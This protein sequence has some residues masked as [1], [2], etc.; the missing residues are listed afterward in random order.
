MDC[1]P[2]G[3]ER[4]S[5][6][7]RNLAGFGKGGEPNFE[8][9]VT[10]LQTR[11]YLVVRDFR[12]RRNRGGLPYGWAIAVYAPPE[13]LWGYEAVIAAY[14]ESPERSG[15]R[16]LQWLEELYPI[17]DRRAAERLIRDGRIR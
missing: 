16:I 6:E 10:A 7:L 9:A 13:E 12:R 1:F 17:P 8:G 3:E 15:E 14:A 2:E 11:L 5:F 4:M